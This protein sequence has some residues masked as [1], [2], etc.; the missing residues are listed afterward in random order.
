MGKAVGVAEKPGAVPSKD[1]ALVDNSKVVMTVG[2]E[3][4]TE[5]Q[6]AAI[7][8]TLPPQYQQQASGPKKREFAEEVANLV[9]L[10]SEAKKRGLDK[11]PSFQARA[12]FQYQNL[13][14]AQMYQA[15]QNA[16]TADDATLRN[17]YDQ[18]K[19]EGEEIQARHILIR[20]KGSQVPLKNGQKDLTEEEALAKAQDIRKQILAGKDFAELA[21]AESDDT[22][23]GTNGGD[24]GKFHKGQ[25][26]PAFEQAAFALPVGELSEPIKTQFGYHIIKVE[27]HSTKTFDQMKPELEARAK[28]EAAKAA[29]EDLRKKVA[30]KFEDSFFG[31]T[32]A[33]PAPAASTPAA[34]APA[35][36]AG[37]APGAKPA[38]PVAQVDK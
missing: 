6:F 10:S 38:P 29:V 28:P 1:P 21:K 25:M 9:V 36:P 37:S 15:I 22:G 7:V 24:L 20:F 4:I 8:A 30:V 11:D 35:A 31:P 3:K 12:Q 17:L 14:A 26:V 23:S 34:P 5:K 18:H 33:A 16:A 32:P 13:L 2:D 19:A 27:N